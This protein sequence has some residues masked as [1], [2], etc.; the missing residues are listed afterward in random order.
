MRSNTAPMATSDALVEGKKSGQSWAYARWMLGGVPPPT[1]HA[2]SSPVF[3]SVLV[4]RPTLSPVEAAG[5][6]GGRV[7]WRARSR[8]GACVGWSRG[9]TSLV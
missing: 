9:L 7:D 4:Q 8:W 3:R 2:R 5:S 1:Q 6:C